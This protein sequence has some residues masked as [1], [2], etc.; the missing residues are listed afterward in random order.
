MKAHEESFLAYYLTADDASAL[1][2]K[3][4]RAGVPPYEVPVDQPVSISSPAIF[5]TPNFPE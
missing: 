1:E 5:L 2:Y 3:R 4:S